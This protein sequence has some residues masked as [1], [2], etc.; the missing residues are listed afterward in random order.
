MPILILAQAAEAAHNTLLGLSVAEWILLGTSL[1]GGIGALLKW[2]EARQAKRQA[3]EL[4]LAKLA[5]E[6]ERDAIIEGVE[7]GNDPMTKQHIRKTALERGVASLSSAVAKATGRLGPPA[8]L[9]LACLLLAGC[10][11][12][13]RADAE[14][15]AV[16]NAGHASDAAIS[17]DARLVAQDNADAWAVQAWELGGPKPADDVFRRLGL[18]A[19]K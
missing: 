17:T 11:G 7:R 8:G 12:K 18:E 9:L 13:A 4:A 16:I 14:A 19:P 6:A 1:A 10:Y 5:V 3:H 15:Y 2:L